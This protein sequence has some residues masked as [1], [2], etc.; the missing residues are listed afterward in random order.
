MEK[1]K[2]YS[3]PLKDDLK[4]EDFSQEFLVKLAKEWQGTALRLEELWF[5]HLEERLG[6]EEA[7]E[8]ETEF[9]VRQ[10]KITLP[11]MAKLANIQVK[12]VID[13]F[14]LAQLMIEGSMGFQPIAT[15]EIMNGNRNHVIWTAKRCLNLEYFEKADPGRII[16]MCHHVEG[17]SITEYLHVFFPNVKVTP[18]KLPPRKNPD[19]IA[20]QWEIVKSEV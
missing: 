18:L 6:K 17:F 2:D 19:E 13:F 20:C 3:G 12:D 1:L 9:W 5:K 14:K 4:L 8:W 11:R 7:D 10:A 16:H 15:Y